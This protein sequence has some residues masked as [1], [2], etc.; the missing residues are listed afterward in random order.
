MFILFALLVSVIT[1]IR[2]I[3]MV[4][5]RWVWQVIFLMLTTLFLL[6]EFII[7]WS[8]FW[9]RC[10]WWQVWR[11][12]F[13]VRVHLGFVPFF[14][15][16]LS[17]DCVSGISFNGVTKSVCCV[18][19]IFSVSCS[20]TSLVSSSEFLI[21]LLYPVVSLTFSKSC[22]YPSLSAP[23]FYLHAL[24]KDLASVELVKSMFCL[25]V[26]SKFRSPRFLNF[27]TLLIE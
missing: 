2:I 6:I 11:W 4:A 10:L 23:K 17:V 27:G 22:V 8:R 25:P 5:R 12:W 24:F 3:I 14:V 20:K 9:W 21:W 19:G 15:F 7:I 16:E 13:W 18:I 1:V 26:A